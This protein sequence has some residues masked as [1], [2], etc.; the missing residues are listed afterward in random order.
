MLDDRR[1][2]DLRPRRHG[3]GRDG[4]AGL[5]ELRRHRP[6]RALR[7]TPTATAPTTAARSSP[8]STATAQWDADM[9][10]AG[11]G[12]PSDVVV[13]RLTYDWGIIT[14]VH[15]AT[16]SARA[17]ATSRA[18]PCA[19]SRSERRRAMRRLLA[20]LRRDDARRSRRVEFALILPILVM[21]SAGIVE[22]GRLILLTQ[23]LQN[24]T[25]I[26]ADLTARDKTL[27][28]EQLDNIFLALDDLVAA[29]RRSPRTAAPS[30]PASMGDEDDDPVIEWQHG[31]AGGLSATSERRRARRDRRPA[32]R[33]LRS[34]RARP[35]SS[36]RSSTT[37]SR[38]SA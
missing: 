26:L 13:Y 32:R 23:K 11:L 4:D 20:R 29:L 19:T 28:E 12:G 35:S 27:C 10:A 6:A 7:R 33:A 9:G 8:T 31:G 37:S 1:G 34:A 25:F 5:R 38:C 3:R 22:F 24:G 15:A 18:S 21:F 17:S 2:Q 30:S 16:S 36:P 14:A